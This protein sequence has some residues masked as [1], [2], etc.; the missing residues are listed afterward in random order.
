MHQFFDLIVPRGRSENTWVSTSFPTRRASIIY[1]R[2]L[3]FSM[4][5]P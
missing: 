2:S 4:Y 1:T 3:L 5:M